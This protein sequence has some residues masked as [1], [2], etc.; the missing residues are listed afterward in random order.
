[1]IEYN[2][3]ARR[4]YFKNFG[5]TTKTRTAFFK[6]FREK[7]KGKI[8]FEVYMP[9]DWDFNT[10]SRVPA[11]AI[12]INATRQAA[13]DEWVAD[14]LTDWQDFTNELCDLLRKEGV[15]SIGIADSSSGYITL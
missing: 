13:P 11:F 8:T 7:F 4:F 6:E 14:R 3:T 1:M 15:M 10:Q 9:D 2:W 12:T 5:L